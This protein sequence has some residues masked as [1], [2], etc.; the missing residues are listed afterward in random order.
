VPDEYDLLIYAKNGHRPQLLEHLAEVFPRHIQIHY[1]RYQREELFEAAR[2]SRACAY[3]ADDDHGP[4]AL[5][6]IL[7]AGCPT[8]GVRT[9]ASFV[10]TGETGVLVNRLPPGRRCVESEDD[11][12]A[13]VA[14]MD[15]LA[16]AQA[17]DR[18]HVRARAA[19]DFQTTGVIDQLIKTL[20]GMRLVPPDSLG[21][22]GV[23]RSTDR[24]RPG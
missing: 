8:V 9:G 19:A 21:R 15:A 14:Y 4:L 2:R 16:Q 18:H 13:L 24:G 10:R 7:L 20:D 6:E 12:A 3:L 23:G 1:G 11:E 22:R 17:F 5:Q